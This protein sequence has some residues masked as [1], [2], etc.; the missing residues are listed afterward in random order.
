MEGQNFEFRWHLKGLSVYKNMIPRL[1][2]ATFMKLTPNEVRTVAT[3]TCPESCSLTRHLYQDIRP[4][5]TYELQDRKEEKKKRKE[6][7]LN[8]NFLPS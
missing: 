5:L 6:K 7:M 2:C 3:V 8:P 4:M 1:K